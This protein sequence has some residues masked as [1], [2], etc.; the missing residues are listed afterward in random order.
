MYECVAL[1]SGINSVMKVE[2]LGTKFLKTT[3]SQ[4][5]HTEGKIQ[6]K[7]GRNK[8]IQTITTLKVDFCIPKTIPNCFRGAW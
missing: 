2:T 6:Q 7:F 1:Y 8:S 4:Y 5:W 3:H